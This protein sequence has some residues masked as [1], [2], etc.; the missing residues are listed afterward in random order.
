VRIVVEAV[1]GCVNSYLVM[2]YKLPKEGAEIEV[3]T[4][5]HWNEVDRMLKLSLPTPDQ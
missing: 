3:E 5:V 1:L 2:R 4:R